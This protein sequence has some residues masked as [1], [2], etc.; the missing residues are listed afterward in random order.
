MEAKRRARAGQGAAW[1]PLIFRTGTLVLTEAGS[2]RLASLTLVRGPDTAHELDPGGIDPLA[3]GPLCGAPV[4]RIA[5]ADNECNYCAECQRRGRL[6][7]D[8]SLLRLM[9]D[10]WPRTLD[11]LEQLE[12]DRRYA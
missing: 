4:Q 12:T 3:C 2:K 1:R 10:D 8:R 7:A 9:H 5:Y 6:L 11:P